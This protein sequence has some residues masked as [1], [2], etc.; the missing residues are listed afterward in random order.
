M[1]CVAIVDDEIGSEDFAGVIDGRRVA[2]CCFGVLLEGAAVVQT[3]DE[4]GW[5]SGRGAWGLQVQVL[6]WRSVGAWGAG[7]GGFYFGKF[8]EHNAY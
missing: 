3:A 1:K 5:G 2:C 4:D 6:R 8:C 7:V